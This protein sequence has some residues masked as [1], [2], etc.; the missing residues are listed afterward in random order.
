MK[1]GLPTE[2]GKWHKLAVQQDLVLVGY[3]CV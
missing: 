3:G 1:P 2:A